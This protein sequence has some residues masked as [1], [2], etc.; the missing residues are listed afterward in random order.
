MENLFLNYIDSNKI[1]DKEFII[2]LIKDYI[3]KNPEIEERLKK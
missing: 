3:E 2:K 1:I